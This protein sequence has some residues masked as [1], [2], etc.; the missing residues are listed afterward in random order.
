L[1]SNE[2]STSS[3]DKHV[4]A[5]NKTSGRTNLWSK[6]SLI[7]SA[8]LAAVILSNGIAE[9]QNYSNTILGSDANFKTR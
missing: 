7:L 9:R 5:H 4:I 6:L 1:T 3:I 8:F 2:H